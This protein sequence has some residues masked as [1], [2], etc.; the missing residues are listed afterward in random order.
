MCK[1]ILVSIRLNNISKKE[2]KQIYIIANIRLADMYGISYLFLASIV[3]SSQCVVYQIQNTIWKQSSYI[4][5][6]R[7]DKTYF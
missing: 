6:T 5:I 7:I 3:N 2:R 4:R 1:N